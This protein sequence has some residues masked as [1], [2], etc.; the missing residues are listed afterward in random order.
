MLNYRVALVSCWSTWQQT[1]LATV[2][3]ESKRRIGGRGITDF[4][5]MN[6]FNGKRGFYNFE[7]QFV[8]T[9]FKYC[10]SESLF[11]NISFSY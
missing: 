10:I 9:S 11:R 2:T 4:L 7:V 8:L 6:T 1:H 3:A 5:T